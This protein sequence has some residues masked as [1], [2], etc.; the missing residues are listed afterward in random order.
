MWVKFETAFQR[1]DDEVVTLSDIQAKRAEILKLAER[2]GAHHVRVFGS[3][4]RGT[5]GPSSD[6]D[7]LVRLEPGRSL[8]DHIALMQDLAEML[9]VNVDIVDEDAMHP[10]IRDKVLTEGLPL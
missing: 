1:P 8:I 6:V 3:V 9:G 7:I 10:L 2:H 5:S 4:V